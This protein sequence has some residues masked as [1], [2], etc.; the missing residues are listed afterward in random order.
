[1]VYEPDEKK[2]RIDERR[3]NQIFERVAQRNRVGDMST[4][5]WLA[6][7]GGAVGIRH[8][9]RMILKSVSDINLVGFVDVRRAGAN[10]TV[11][12]TAPSIIDGGTF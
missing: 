6:A 2:I 1:M 3:L 5:D 8:N 7:A 4:R 11:E 10:V 12:I 9:R